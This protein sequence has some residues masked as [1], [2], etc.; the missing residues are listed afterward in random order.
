M[1]EQDNKKTDY[2]KESGNFNHRASDVKDNLFIHNDFFDPHDI[3]QVK[4]EMLRKVSKENCPVTEAIH[5]FG[6]SRPY[7]YKL[8]NAFDDKG[9]MG[10]LPQKRGPKDGFKLKGHIVE[11]VDRTLKKEPTLTNCHIAKEIETRF[12]ITLHP[13]TIDRLRKGQ[14]K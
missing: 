6:M 8:K 10:L 2:L 9:M 1:S 12:Y 3:M 13:R 7:Y 5:L 11:F 4:Y 14:K